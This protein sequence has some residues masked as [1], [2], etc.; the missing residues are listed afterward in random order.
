MELTVGFWVCVWLVART[1]FG[2]LGYRTP[3]SPPCP[4]MR[5]QAHA[6]IQSLVLCRLPKGLALGPVP[7]AGT[8]LQQQCHQYHRDKRWPR[9]QEWLYHRVL[10]DGILVPACGGRH[11][12]EPFPRHPRNSAQLPGTLIFFNDVIGQIILIGKVNTADDNECP[13]LSAP[14]HRGQ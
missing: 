5:L 3:V 13:G 4:R 10:T 12:T 2:A 11:P 8:S 14:A 1:I 7:Q 9:H 6:F